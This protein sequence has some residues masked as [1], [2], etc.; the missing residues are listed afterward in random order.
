MNATIE[1]VKKFWENNPLFTDESEHPVNSKAFFEE[2]RSVYMQDVFA[3]KFD[4]E[5]FIPRLDNARVLDLGCGVGFWTIEIQKRRNTGDFY[6]ADLTEAA[7]EAT[8]KRLQ[9]YNCQSNLSIQNAEDLKFE[10]GY[11]DFVNCQGV[12]HHTVNPQRAI[13]E[14]A[15]VLKK[16]GK[17]SI[18]VYYRN[19]VL[20][21][22]SIFR[23]IARLLGNIGA[24][25]KG[26]GRESIYLEEDKD[27][28][29]R[30]Y[31]GQDNPIGI[32]YS[33][34]EL[35]AALEEYF[36]IDTWFL[37]FFPA[38]TLPFKLPKSIHRLLAK[39]FGFMIHVNLIKK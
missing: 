18:S 11:F 13:N 23:G 9:L 32:S 1:D 31:D 8:A 30:L 38:R 39:Y 34:K 20:R 33:K 16:G 17:A 24:K 29:I 27:E 26:R 36:E 37:Y 10:D 35:R 2:H 25:L 22:W 5:K 15:R 7:L 3:G 6:S 14:I 21:N 12:I 28:I 4:D 19:F